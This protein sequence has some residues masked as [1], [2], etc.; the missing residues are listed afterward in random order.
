MSE[1]IK[2]MSSDMGIKPYTNEPCQSFVFRVI[3]SALGRWCLESARADVGISKHGQTAL[4]N[5]LT[6]K[7]VALFPEI[8]EMIVQDGQTPI[9]VFIR[10]I[11][12]ETGFLITNSDNHNELARYQRGIEIGS[13]KLLCGLA[14]EVSNE[15]LGIYSDD[16]KYTVHWKEALIR[17][18][19]S[20]EEYMS[21]Q[22]DLT[23]FSPRDIAE[24]NLLFFNPQTNVAPSSA[25]ISEMTTDKTVARY[26]GTYYRVM[27]Y[28]GE[29]LF[30]EEV[31]NAGTD[32]LT[33]F[34]YRR[35][36]CAL[37][38]HYGYPLMG[39]VQSLDT[40]YAKVTF[41]GHLPNREY[42]FLLLCAWPCRT[43]LNKRE[44]II[45]KDYLGLLNEVLEN[46]GIELDGG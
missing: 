18:S 27:R 6:E 36:Y 33:D 37:K 14:P 38:K 5:N 3:Y 21:S 45:K 20:C 12:E 13:K 1:L 23:L 7:Y 19:L 26:N 9:S 24:D 11:Y 44:F 28:N 34:E 16:V 4:L 30:D 39:R 46:I 31:P 15:G 10:H 25:W 42:F 8:K 2:A 22:Y 35:L 43:Y 29:L 40:Q 17:D 32:G 41:G